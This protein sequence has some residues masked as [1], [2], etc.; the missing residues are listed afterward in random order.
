LFC[1]SGGP[2][3]GTGTETVISSIFGFR[4]LPRT[5][6]TSGREGL[7]LELVVL[8]ALFTG[9]FVEVGVF[10]FEGA[11]FADLTGAGDFLGIVSIS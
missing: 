7:A 2:V 6:F 1:A 10:A 4:T 5:P 3:L 11:F 8:V 9:F